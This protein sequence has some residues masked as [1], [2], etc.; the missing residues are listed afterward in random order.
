MTFVHI[1]LVYKNTLYYLNVHHR[2][3]MR[4]LAG[5]PEEFFKHLPGKYV[6]GGYLVADYDKGVLVNG[7]DVIKFPTIN[8]KAMTNG[9][10]LLEVR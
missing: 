6:D 3:A 7:Q 2:T 1:T 10:K 8:G 5:G 9:L 4:L